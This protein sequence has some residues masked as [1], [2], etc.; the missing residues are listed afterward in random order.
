MQPLGSPACTIPKS[1]S[2]HFYERAMKVGVAKSCA[3]RPLCC[4]APK[5]ERGVEIIFIRPWSGLKRGG[6][7]CGVTASL[8]VY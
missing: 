6:N 2:T 7:N 4:V 3:I 1:G 5:I 8:E